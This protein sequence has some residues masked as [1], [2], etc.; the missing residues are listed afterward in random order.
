M[1]LDF[2]YVVWYPI[3]ERRRYF[4]TFF[5]NMFNNVKVAKD[6]KSL[7]AKFK[8]FCKN[9]RIDR[10]QKLSRIWIIPDKAEKPTK[11]AD[12]R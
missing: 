10:V 2:G 5:K 4:A 3:C 8:S 7:N 1:V 11:S 12:I 6:G 9:V